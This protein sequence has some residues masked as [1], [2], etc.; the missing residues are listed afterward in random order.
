MAYAISLKVVNDPA[1][2]IRALWEEVAQFE[3]RPSMAALGYPP[4]LTLAVYDDIPLVQASN[5]LREAFAGRSALR[6]TF[7][8]LRF[9][10]D[11]LVLWA[12]PSPSADLTSAHARVHALID[13][14]HCHPRYRP[15]AWVPHCTLGTQ[16]LLKYREEALAFAA[17]TI[18]AF[19]VIF[20]VAD[21]VSLAPVF[22]M[23]E[24]P[25]DRPG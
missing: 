15:G 12:E 4:H 20:D 19:E 10:D 8:R 14:R 17:R 22:I 16:I 9:F 5:V 25:L 2:P 23:A 6:L 21:C 3:S 11:P 13:P 24:Q 18:A 7:T 1:G